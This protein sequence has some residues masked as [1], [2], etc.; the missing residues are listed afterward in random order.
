MSKN[1]TVDQVNISESENKCKCSCNNNHDDNISHINQD[2]VLNINNLDCANCAAKIERELNKCDSISNVNISFMSKKIYY[3]TNL[4]KKEAIEFINNELLKIEDGVYVSDKIT[5]QEVKDYSKSKIIISVILVIIALALNNY[6]YISYAL[7][8]ISYLIVGYEVLIRA[9]KNIYNKKFFD[10]NF[11]MAIATIGALLINEIHEAAAVMIFYQIG[12]YFQHQAVEKSR[13]SIANLMDIKPEFANIKSNNKIV[14]IAPEFVKVGDIIIVK[15]GEKVP[16]DGVII[17]GTTSLNSLA[18]TGESIPKLVDVGSEVSSGMINLEGL[19][20]IKVLKEYKDSNVVKILNLVENVSSNKAKAENFIT[21]F[22]KYY[23]P[24]VVILALIIAFIVPLFIL[25]ALFSDYIYR[26]LTFLVISCPCALVISVPL[27]YFAGIGG[28]SKHGILVKGGNYLDALSKIDTIVLDKTGTITKGDFAV[29]KIISD[30]IDLCI[31]YAAHLEM[32]SNHPIAKSIVKKYDGNFDLI[33]EDVKEISGRGI[34]A[35]IDKDIFNIGNYKYMENLNI[36]VKKYDEIGTLVYLAKNN[37]F[38]GVLVI[39]DQVK[40]SSIQ[41]IEKLKLLKIKSIMLTGDNN[42]IAK[43]VSEITKID[44]YYS[45]LLPQD[46]VIKLNEIKAMNRK[47][48]FVGDGINDAPVITIADVGFAMGGIGSDAAIEAADIVITN[49]NLNNII[50]AIKGSK[51][52]KKIVLQNIVGALLVKFVVLLLGA[53]GHATMWWAIF[54]DVG[55]SLIA[56]LN[57]IRALR[58]K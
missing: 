8:M 21:K 9:V 54:A 42:E 2:F 11:L 27:T 12:E 36:D 45:E 31:K 33:V 49:D 56:I 10:E 22:A 44:E 48:A 17:K 6:T 29:D 47:V 15:A 16:V 46:K 41:A 37:I 30:N 38:Y 26:G 34:S 23:T 57:A 5:K 25:G 3:N 24:I 19:I 52:T 28:L 18:L 40:N 7:F 4:E 53:T 51:I 55:V 39:K 1:E 20:E 50:L 58:V 35:T 13:S 43:E 14:K 32:N